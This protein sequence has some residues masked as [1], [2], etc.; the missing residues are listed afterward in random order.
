MIAPRDHKLVN[1]YAV[2]LVFIFGLY[3]FQ[4]TD[5]YILNQPTMSSSAFDVALADLDL[6]GK[7]ELSAIDGRLTITPSQSTIEF[8]SDQVSESDVLKAKA[9]LAKLAAE[10]GCNDK[11]VKC[12][13]SLS[14][15]AWSAGLMPRA[16]SSG[17][18]R[19]KKGNRVRFRC[20]RN[21]YHDLARTMPVIE[22]QGL[23]STVPYSVY[24]RELYKHGVNN[25]VIKQR[26]VQEV[27][28]YLKS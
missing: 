8:K 25:R 14:V 13:G 20:K 23:D 4:P 17:G 19:S 26:L 9:L 7:F 3:Y 27:Y 22:F 10:L 24:G 5:Q 1:C 6:L 15:R 18:A 28:D 16:Q 12:V 21:P 11:N 2:Y